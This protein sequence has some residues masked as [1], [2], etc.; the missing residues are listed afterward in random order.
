MPV[1][2]FAPAR[3]LLVEAVSDQAFP[4][5]SA[6]VGRHDGAV[7][8]ATVG[9]LTYEPD[10]LPVSDGT[11]FD[12][13]SLTKVVATTTVAMRFVDEGR[14]DLDD[15][16]ADRLS[17]WR[18]GD[19]E[20][21]TIR[22]VLAHCSGLT[23]YLPY[24]RDHSGRRDYE[25]AICAMPLEYHP[26]SRSIYSD[27]GFMLLG[28]ILEDAGAEPLDAL[29]RPVADRVAPDPL[30]FRPPKSWKDRTAPTELDPWRGRLLNGD[31]HDENCWALGG[32][33]G[34]AGLFGTA[35]AVGSFAR[36][37][38]RTIAGDPILATTTT[39]HQFIRGTDVLGSSRALGWD[40]MRPTSSCGTHMSPA[41]IG[42]TG[43]TG[44]S[45]WIDPERDVYAVLLTNRVHPSR[46]NEKILAVRAAF[47]N[48]VMQ[49]LGY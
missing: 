30:A 21:V 28:F 41:A 25:H 38:L 37:M 3:H 44:T 22:D 36:L 6:E 34:H 32:V 10:A 2:S 27:L 40:T 12:L 17:D 23:A 5:S 24:F 47:H 15:R 7:W 29:F 9:A 39:I 20:T 26:R 4:G 46:S 13:A 11:I 1:D 8:R 35:S 45:L 42:H 49:S 31:V 33:A 16:L 48:L 19:R 18:G 14:L 43:F